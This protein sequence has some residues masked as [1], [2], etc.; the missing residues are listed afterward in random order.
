LRAVIDPKDFDGIP[1]DLIDGDIGRK[2]Q[3]AQPDQVSG[4]A[5]DGIRA[6]TSRP[7]SALARA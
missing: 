2:G 3:L 4:A 6:G 1:L 5:N 7:A